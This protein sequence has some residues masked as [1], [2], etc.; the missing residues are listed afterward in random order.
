MRSVGLQKMSLKDAQYIF[1]IR[2]FASARPTVYLPAHDPM[3][4]TRLARRQVVP[5]GVALKGAA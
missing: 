5:V 2:Q 1:A 4:G 3:S